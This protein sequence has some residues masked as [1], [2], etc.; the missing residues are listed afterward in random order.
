M[1]V[2]RVYHGDEELFAVH[3]SDAIEFPFEF[4]VE[5]EESPSMSKPWLLLVWFANEPTPEWIRPGQT[6]GAIQFEFTHVSH[7][8]SYAD[9]L[10]I[11]LDETAPQ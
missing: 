8:P 4:H 10:E 6:F 7:G 3:H 9:G 1:K 2:L 11:T 5:G